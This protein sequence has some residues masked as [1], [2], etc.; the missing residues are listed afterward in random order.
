MR[1]SM[2]DAIVGTMRD[3]NKSGVVDDITLRNIEKLC[4]PD[5]HDYTP[6]DIAALRKQLSLSQGALAKIFNISL[7]TVQKWEQGLK[8][9]AG[10]AKKLLD[11]MERK[12]LEAFV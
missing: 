7:S 10:D 1:K 5:V 11:I 4:V 8:K 2:V 12:G 3:L 9:P 6:E